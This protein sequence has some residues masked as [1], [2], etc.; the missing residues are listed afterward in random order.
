[1]GP[2]RAAFDAAWKEEARQAQDRQREAFKAMR[3]QEA[4]QGR[5]HA[6]TRTTHR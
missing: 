4:A 5:S 3:S 2:D 6:I 1:M